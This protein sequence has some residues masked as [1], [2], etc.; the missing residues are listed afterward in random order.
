MQSRAPMSQPRITRWLA[1][2][3]SSSL[4]LAACTDVDEEPYVGESVEGLSLAES[5]P[6]GFYGP[7]TPAVF[8]GADW[9]VRVVG[10]NASGNVAFD[11]QREPGI[12]GTPSPTLVGGALRA[13]YVVAAEDSF[14][15]TVVWAVAGTWLLRAQQTTPGSR[16]F[17]DWNYVDTSVLARKPAL[18][19]NQDGRLELA[20]VDADGTVKTMWQTSPAGG[21]SSAVATGYRTFGTPELMRDRQNRLEL[22][23]P[24]TSTPC[25][26]IYLR[27]RAANGA[28]GWFPP[29]TL[30]GPCLSTLTVG[31]ADDA[32]DVLGQLSTGELLHYTR[33]G[34]DLLF[35]NGPL[36][37]LR[38]PGARPALIAKDDG[39]LF[40][41]AGFESCQNGSPPGTVGCGTYLAA[42]REYGGWWAWQP[43]AISSRNAPIAGADSIINNTHIFAITGGTLQYDRSLF[44]Y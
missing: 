36:G 6:S 40:A 37:G 38:S 25:G 21:W 44:Q 30:A 27:Q 43:F 17:N 16:V 2:S 22:F 15:R 42:Q 33:Q 4:L 29:T 8:R 34:S 11:L 26:F 7:V 39:R 5:V 18:A 35:G 13:Q 19:V 24:R 3:L 23:V 9:R 31:Y 12:W 14:G 1:L 41:F 10:A 20:Y 28:Q 32:T